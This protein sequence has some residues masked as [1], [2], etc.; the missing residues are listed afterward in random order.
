MKESEAVEN[1]TRAVELKRGWENEAVKAIKSNI[2]LAY[3][4]ALKIMRDQRGFTELST[5]DRQNIM[6]GA[7]RTAFIEM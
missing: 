7:A 2:L 6:S 3:A 5:V 1:R 4:Q